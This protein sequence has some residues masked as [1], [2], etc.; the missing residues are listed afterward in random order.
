MVVPFI[1]ILDYIIAKFFYYDIEEEF[2]KVI[3]EGRVTKMSLL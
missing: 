3:R 1:S 2:E